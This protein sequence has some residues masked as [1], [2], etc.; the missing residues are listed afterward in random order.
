[1]LERG[2]QTATRG[3]MSKLQVRCKDC[4][5]NS[6]VTCTT[7]WELDACVLRTS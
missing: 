4:K 6:E 7:Y 1:M 2:V 3:N 5:I